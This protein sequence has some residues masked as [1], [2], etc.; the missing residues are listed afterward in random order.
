MGY[1]FL[2]LGADVEALNAYFQKTAKFALE[3]GANQL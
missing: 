2:N 1:Q 3:N